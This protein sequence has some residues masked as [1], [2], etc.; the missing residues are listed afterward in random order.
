MKT[1]RS[2]GGPFVGVAFRNRE[3][4]GDITTFDRQRV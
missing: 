4:S 2:L 3:V 1:D